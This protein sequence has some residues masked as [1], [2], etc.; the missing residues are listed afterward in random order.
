MFDPTN[1]KKND[2]LRAEKSL[3]YNAL[4]FRAHRLTGEALKP[5]VISLALTHR[6]NSHCLMCNLWKRSR[7]VP[8]IKS[9]EMSGRE[10]I[11]ILTN[12]LCSQLVEL[13][14]T[15]GEPHLRDDLAEL[16]SNIARLKPTYLPRLRSIIYHFER[17]IAGH[18]L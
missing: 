15:G 1:I 9:L 10:I 4:K 8:E 3:V 18:H 11:E 17:S 14:L 13:D 7:E 12:P 6:C 16:A 5:S 2:Y